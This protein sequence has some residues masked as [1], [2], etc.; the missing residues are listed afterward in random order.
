ME[1]K[2]NTIL[3]VLNIFFYI[4]VFILSILSIILLLLL[5]S[6]IFT[7]NI[8]LLDNIKF[9]V[10]IFNKKIENV[11]SLGRSMKIFLISYTLIFCIAFIYLFILIIKVLK[12]LKNSHPFSRETAHLILKI[13]NGFFYLGYASILIDFIFEIFKGEISFSYDLGS[14]NL[15]FFLLAGVIYVVGQVYKRGVE[16]Q[17]ENDLTI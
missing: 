3:D 10:N 13:S 9:D 1:N 17:S 11:L 5:V 8:G 4:T 7:F 6:N 14:Q 12:K 15:Q 2:S 16:L